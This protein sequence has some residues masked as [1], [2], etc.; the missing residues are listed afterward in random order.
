MRKKGFTLIELLVVIAIIALLLAIITPALKKAKDA[1]RSITC[2]SNLKQLGLGFQSYYIENNN[3][4]LV[5]EGAEIFW[6]IQIGPYLGDAA[7]TFN[8]GLDPEMEMSSSMATVKCPS[9]KSPTLEWDS[10][11]PATSQGV[12]GT[13]RN[14]FRYHMTR[15]EGSYGMNRWVGGWIGAMGSGSFNPSRPAG[16]ANL[17]KSY[18]DA[19]CGKASIPLIVDAIW[20]D[21][22]P[23]TAGDLVPNAEQLKTGV[24]DGLG[25]GCTD[26]HGVDTNVIYCDGHAEKIKLTE[27]WSQRWHK[28]FA[29]RYDVQVPR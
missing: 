21:L 20:V 14:Q 2:R 1:A 3:K 10:S 13:A 15:V 6:F 24:W 18:R 27:L 17:K 8:A 26:R 29:P 11:Q 28:E 7:F 25:R 5:S 12:E 9:T 22:M 4:A 19:A 23:M 16:R